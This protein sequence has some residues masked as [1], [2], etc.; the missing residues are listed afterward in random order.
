[1]KKENKVYTEEFKHQIAK[2]HASGKTSGE[3]EKEY[4]VSRTTINIWVKQYAGTG[5]YGLVSNYVSRRKKRK[6]S[7]VNDAQIA[8][9]VNREFEPERKNTKS[10][11]AQRQACGVGILLG[12]DGFAAN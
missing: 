2:L 9:V 11:S 4:G 10:S 5:K 3:L 7:D 6:K 1:M 12:S 8:N